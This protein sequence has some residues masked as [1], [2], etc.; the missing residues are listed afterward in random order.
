[1][2]E[3]DARAQ[4]AEASEAQAEAQEGKPLPRQ[5][6]QGE[7]EASPPPVDFYCDT[8]ND[9]P[10]C[11]ESCHHGRCSTGPMRAPMPNAN[12]IAAVCCPIARWLAL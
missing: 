8:F 12:A 1:M 2:G 5:P 7:D 9:A 3:R 6:V 4:E 10:E 11:C